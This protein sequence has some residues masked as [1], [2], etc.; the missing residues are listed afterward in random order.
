MLVLGAVMCAAVVGAAPDDLAPAAPES[1]DEVASVRVDALPTELGGEWL[2]R[3]GHDPAWSSPFRERRNW[4][5]IR[6]PGRWDRQGYG[7]YDGHAWYLLRILIPSRFA[8]EDL[9]VDLGAIADVDEVFLNGRK[10]GATGS[11]PP[12]FRL[13][14]L[15]RRFYRLPQESLRVGEY[16]ELAIHVYKA[17][18]FGGL[19]G[20]TPAIDRAS[21]LLAASVHR[22]LAVFSVATFLATLALLQ[23]GLFFSSGRE[24]TEHL[25]FAC[26]LL[27]AAVYFSTFTTWGPA[28]VIGPA[29]DYRLHVATLLGAVVFFVPPTQHYLNRKIP[30]SVVGLITLFALGIAF[31]LAWRRAEDLYIWVW[32]AEAAIVVVGVMALVGFWTTARR[33]RIRPRL[34]FGALAL[35]VGTSVV[36]I[37]RDLDLLP[38]LGD[39][40]PG[41]LAMLGILPFAMIFS[42]TLF[43]RWVALH[44]G[45]P[46]DRT[47]GLLPRD[48]FIRRLSSEI[49]RVA[50]SDSPL[51]VAL[52]RIPPESDGRDPE[53]LAA[54]TAQVLRRSLRQ[55]DAVGR[56]HA[57]TFAVLLA[58]TEDRG[59]TVVVERLRRA[60]S[61]SLPR[62]QGRAVVSAGLAQYRP[63]RHASSR[64]LL[65]EAEAALYAALA[66]GGDCTATA[67]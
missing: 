59:A 1:A 25:Y 67:P 46:F 17:G 51:S 37:A 32:A 53:L 11:F 64:E 15:S 27:D 7:G 33:G 61:E 40:F 16:N 42:L 66:E 5:T 21:E 41:N 34:V 54:Q 36:D 55:I 52:L 4:Q 28:S 43:E 45:E 3:L 26:F 31:A 48:R 10:A 18:R 35:L 38:R 9:A 6:V 39:V 63:N 22:D 2:F 49:E 56:H 62:G 65:D 44:W 19:I 8:G 14:T 58:D 60:V 47:T 20:P 12:R 29:W 24:E 30:H 23:L 50:R 57:D 13:A